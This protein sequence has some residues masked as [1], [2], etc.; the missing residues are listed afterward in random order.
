MTAFQIAATE[1]SENCWHQMVISR[2]T[3]R[4]TDHRMSS[5]QSSDVGK[6]VPT[7]CESING[8]SISTRSQ[9]ILLEG[10]VVR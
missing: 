6:E 5:E 7:F 8:S 4:M 10:G 2:W 1:P 9:E 3:G